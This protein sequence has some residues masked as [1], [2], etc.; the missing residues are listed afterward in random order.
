MIAGEGRPLLQRS[1]GH[2]HPNYS[3]EHQQSPGNSVD[4]VNSFCGKLVPEETRES[5]EESEPGKGSEGHST[6]ESNHLAGIADHALNPDRGKCGAES[7]ECE[8]IRECESK[9]GEECESL[10]AL[11]LR[12]CLRVG[13]APQEVES[14]PQQD[15]A[16][17]ESHPELLGVDEL[18]QQSNP[19]GCHEGVEDICRGP[20]QPHN[21]AAASAARKGSLDAQNANGSDG[22][23][24]SEPDDHA[25]N[26]GG[27]RENRD[28]RVI[29]DRAS[30]APEQPLGQ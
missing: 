9:Y 1:E 7:K 15:E 30:T 10:G 22:D 14:C 17:E 8:G 19:E 2:H 5:G 26:D 18:H 21:E 12:G 11:P 28:K 24:K 3:E 25:L 4:H 29:K 20:A 27:H 16:P 13:A 6:N 23:G